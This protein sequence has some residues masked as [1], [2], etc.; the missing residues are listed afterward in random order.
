MPTAAVQDGIAVAL[1]LAEMTACRLQA[2]SANTTGDCARQPFALL[3]QRLLQLCSNLSR[4]SDAAVHALVPNPGPADGTTTSDTKHDD[5]P[6]VVSS[7]VAVGSVALCNDAAP[8]LASSYLRLLTNLTATD[9]S[10]ASS[11]VMLDLLLAPAPPAGIGT[12][13]LS[14][15]LLLSAAHEDARLGV[16]S[17]PCA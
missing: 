5:R 2:L 16:S 12:A 14:A 9:A 17:Q 6:S 15:Q 8:E 13:M 3:T 11:A 7:L 4:T 1:G 10:A